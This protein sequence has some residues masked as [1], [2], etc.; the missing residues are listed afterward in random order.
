MTLPDCS[1]SPSDMQGQ[2]DNILSRLAGLEEA[3]AGL[4]ASDVNAIQLSDISPS[5]GW[6]YDVTYMGMPGWTQTAAGTLIPPTGFSISTASLF[7]NGA[8]TSGISGGIGTLARFTGGQPTLTI[9]TFTLKDRTDTVIDVVSPGQTFT[10][11]STGWY[12][13]FFNVR[14]VMSAPNTVVA[15]ASLI[16]YDSG[17]VEV[18]G[19]KWQLDLRT[20]GMTGTNDVVIVLSPVFKIVSTADTVAF[21]SSGLNNG[22]QDTYSI[23]TIMKIRDL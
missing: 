16:H 18:D 20:S 23:S 19:V 5:V 2:I 6:V 1:V 22:T 9:P 4:A 11:T 17:S 10:F 13:F 7:P 15:R 8:Q 3:V 14:G 12:A 21:S